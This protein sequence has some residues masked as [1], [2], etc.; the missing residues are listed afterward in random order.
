[1]SDLDRKTHRLLEEDGTVT[2][3]PYNK[4]TVVH[5]S[6]A[7]A[8]T[9][10]KIRDTIRSSPN[11]NV[12]SSMRFPGKQAAQT[13]GSAYQEVLRK[14][15]QPQGSRQAMTAVQQPNLVTRSAP[16]LAANSATDAARAAARGLRKESV[17]GKVLKNGVNVSTAES[18]KIESTRE[19][20]DL[21]VREGG[22]TYDEALD[23]IVEHEG[24]DL[25]ER[26]RA[27]WGLA[28]GLGTAGLNL[29][30]SAV[31]WAMGPAFRATAK[32]SPG[33]FKA[34]A[35]LVSKNIP[36]AP[37]TGAATAMR[38]A[39]K[40]SNPAANLLRAQTTGAALKGGAKV[41]GSM[42]SSA[43][44]SAGSAAKTVGSKVV[45][46]AKNPVVGGALGYGIGAAVDRGLSGSS[47]GDAPATAAAPKATPAKSSAPN[48]TPVPGKSQ[49]L[50]DPTPV[51]RPWDI[52]KDLKADNAAAPMKQSTEPFTNAQLDAGNKLAAATPVSTSGGA[53]APAASSAPSGGGKGLSKFGKAFL[54]ARDAGEKEFSFGGKQYHT[55]R[56]GE[57]D[58]AWKSSL[59]GSKPVPTQVRV[60]GGTAV[61]QGKGMKDEPVTQTMS[62]G[63]KTFAQTRGGDFEVPSG[64]KPVARTDL[65]GTPMRTGKATAPGTLL[66]GSGSSF[67]PVSTTTAAP[68]AAAP[69]KSTASAAPAPK[70]EPA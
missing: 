18:R 13:T 57:T 70:P 49:S 16:G 12:P 15:D 40:G 54:A 66:P 55:R 28:K 22:M 24:E 39:A 34:G 60:S 61:A 29:G 31:G 11:V 68:A 37:K 21:L 69:S 8:R 19:V 35:E 43:A 1:M 9:F 32:T 3:S 65:G 53:A 10:G 44:S 46:V 27:L 42:A 7:M 50:F 17:S 56:A 47:T 48:S 20:F 5:T 45:G 38:L 2:A 14:G 33:A 41:V 36:G 6:P 67:K 51:S 4:D 26:V 30:K 52:Y 58:T 25:D 59:G 62:Y 23:F 63:G 64:T